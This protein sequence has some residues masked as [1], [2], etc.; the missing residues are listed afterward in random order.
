MPGHGR[1]VILLRAGTIH[2]AVPHGWPLV[3]Y[4][5]LMCRSIKTLRAPYATGVTDEDMRAAAL[6]YVQ[7][8]SGFRLPSAA[9]A[10]AFNH[11]VE[12]VTAVT[13]ELLAVLEANATDRVGLGPATLRFAAFPWWAHVRSALSRVA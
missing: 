10:Y 13:R 6:Q 11:A 12:T 9:T 8:V 5:H 1:T 7:T 2:R 4:G 3:A